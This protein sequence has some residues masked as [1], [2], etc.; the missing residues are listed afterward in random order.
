MSIMDDVSDGYHTFGEL[1]KH[2]TALFAALCNIT[3]D[4]LFERDFNADIE[5][6]VYKSRL[7]D[8]GTMFKGMFLAA[9]LT[10]GGWVSYHCD[11]VYWEWFVIPEREKALPWTGYTP[12]DVI[13]RLTMI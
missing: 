7:H 8:D 6:R 3:K 1:Y 13:Y 4:M 10:P 9:L 5:A 12:N 11:S 2:R